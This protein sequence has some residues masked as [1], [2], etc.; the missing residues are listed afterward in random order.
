MK[1]IYSV[2]SIINKHIDERR[3]ANLKYWSPENGYD[4]EE[5]QRNEWN[6]WNTHY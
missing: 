6:D 5:K 3:E 2:N 1:E 4:D